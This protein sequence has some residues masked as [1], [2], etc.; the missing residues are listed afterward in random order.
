MLTGQLWGVA[1][2][3][4]QIALKVQLNTTLFA[5]TLLRKDVATSSSSLSTEADGEDGPLD[6]PGAPLDADDQNSNSEG[7]PAQPR[8]TKL[9][10]RSLSAQYITD[11]YL[12]W[13]T[14]TREKES[15]EYIKTLSGEPTH[16]GL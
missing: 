14:K 6:A 8:T 9:G 1:T 15:E 11:I 10:P 5:K 12:H 2:T 16:D 3:T 7:G 13:V 4:L